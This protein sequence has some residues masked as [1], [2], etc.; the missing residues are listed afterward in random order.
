[1]GQ[2]ESQLAEARRADL[3]KARI[4][5]PIEGVVSHRQVDVGDFVDKGTPLTI[6]DDQGLDFTANVSALDLVHVVEGQQIVFSVDGLHS[7]L[8]G[9]VH[10]VN[11]TSSAMTARDTF[12]PRSR[13]VKAC[14]RAVLRGRVVL[15]E[16]QD[17]LVLPRKLALLE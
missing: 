7:E 11:P 1:M 15:E 6:V 5:A 3:T 4:C 8:R 12:R 16:R 13:T 9:R 10:R 2:A 17:V 14:S